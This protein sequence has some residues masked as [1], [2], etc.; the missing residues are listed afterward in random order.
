MPGLP[1]ARKCSAHKK[2]GSPCPQPA[3]DNGKC[4]MHGG[5][6]LKGVAVHNYKHGR[7]SKYMPAG[8]MNMYEEAR[9][10]ERR[11]ELDEEIAL[12]DTRMSDTLQSITA[13][14]T[15]EAWGDIRDLID[16]LLDARDNGLPMN[17]DALMDEL[18]ET[19]EQKFA[20]DRSWGDLMQLT[21]TRRK[22]VESQRKR[23]IEL[24]QMMPIAD[25]MAVGK[26]LLDSVRRNVTDAKQLTA[27]QEDFSRT[28][29]TA[30][31][32][33]LNALPN[34]GELYE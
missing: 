8:L 23:E 13:G 28:I 33:R 11:L 20:A 7:H 10:D 22:L 24:R 17:A 14:A 9:A 15:H 16:Q 25:V 4:R 12:V 32:D 19:V 2:D 3:M 18:K 1:N 5:K 26:L 21:D 27:I 34:A 31:G 6:A 30:F 29:R